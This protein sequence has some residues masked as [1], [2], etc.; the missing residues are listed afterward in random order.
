M[1]IFNKGTA[2]SNSTLK[3]PSG[4]LLAYLIHTFTIVLLCVLPTA[5]ACENLSPLFI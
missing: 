5:A 3:G 1:L 2:Q 4:T